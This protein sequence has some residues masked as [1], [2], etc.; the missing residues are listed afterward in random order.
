MCGNSF[1]APVVL[2]GFPQGFTPISHPQ[3]ATAQD[4]Y[5]QSYQY[6]AVGNIKLMSISLCSSIGGGRS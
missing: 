6:D 4:T 1:S 5:T 3:D 2:D